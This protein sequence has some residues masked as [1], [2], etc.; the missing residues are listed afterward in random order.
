MANRNLDLTWE[1]L[2][3]SLCLQDYLSL[4]IS[5]AQ[6]SLRKITDWG[7][8]LPHMPFW[9]CSWQNTQGNFWHCF[10]CSSL[11]EAC[12]T[13]ITSS[14]RGWRFCQAH[15]LMFVQ[16]MSCWGRLEWLCSLWLCGPLWLCLTQGWT[17][18]FITSVASHTSS[19]GFWPLGITPN[20]KEN[21]S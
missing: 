2:K 7:R 19:F 4:F 14:F 20:L 18:L 9:G 1:D 5:V 11:P 13:Q 10:P 21:L 12:V 6:K 17:Q 16:H 3:V 15:C 8:F